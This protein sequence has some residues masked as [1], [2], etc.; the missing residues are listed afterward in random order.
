MVKN[1]QAE[2][3]NRV[4]ARISNLQI[5]DFLD[6]PGLFASVLILIDY[7]LIGTD[8]HPSGFLGKMSRKELKICQG[9]ATLS[10]QE[11]KVIGTPLPKSCLS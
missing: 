4:A 11:T 5:N 6:K 1:R 2:A 3:R 8:A 7:N 9:L 10:Q